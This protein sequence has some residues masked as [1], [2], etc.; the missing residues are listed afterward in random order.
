MRVT[1]VKE[2]DFDAKLEILGRLDPMDKGR[3]PV[4]VGMEY[5]V[6]FVILY[7]KYVYFGI[8]DEN[9]MMRAHPAALFCVIDRRLSRYWKLRFRAAEAD[10]TPEFMVIGYQEMV[11]NDDHLSGVFEF[12]RKDLSIALSYKEKLDL[13]FRN[14]QVAQNGTLIEGNYVSCPVCADGFESSPFDELLRCPTCGAI[15]NNPLAKP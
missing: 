9:K 6:Y 10:H 11:E 2:T 4:T 13:E 1:C 14:D 7:H 12:N 15:L 8:W 5:N 3:Y